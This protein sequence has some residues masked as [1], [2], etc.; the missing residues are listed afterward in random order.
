LI[1][2]AYLAPDLKHAILDG[3]Q[4]RRLT[5]QTVMTGKLPLNW[6]DQQ[7]MFSL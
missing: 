3:K 5:L 7:R 2:V 6:V 1:R 4:L